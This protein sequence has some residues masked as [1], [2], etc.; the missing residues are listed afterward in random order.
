MNLKIKFPFTGVAK[1]KRRDC[2]FVIENADGSLQSPVMHKYVNGK[3]AIHG[4]DPRKA[5]HLVAT[6]TEK[7]WKIRI[8]KEDVEIIN[9][10][11]DAEL[12]ARGVTENRVFIDNT[13]DKRAVAAVFARFTKDMESLGYTREPKMDM[14][15]VRLPIPTA[16]IIFPNFGSDRAP[17]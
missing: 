17:M 15:V 13:T 2:A 10:L 14:D 11:A 9:N 8:I 4:A 5:Q 7:G 12:V 1:P 3:S 16:E 6:A